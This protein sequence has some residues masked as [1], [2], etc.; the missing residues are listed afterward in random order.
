MN[1]ASKGDNLVKKLIANGFTTKGAKKAAKS[2]ETSGKPMSA[3]V[4]TGERAGLLKKSVSG[5]PKATGGK[6][7]KSNMKKAPGPFYM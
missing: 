4:K 1:H 7:K 3:Y 5:K 6:A 2:M